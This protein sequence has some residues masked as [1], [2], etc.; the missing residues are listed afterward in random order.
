[1]G[2]ALNYH[3][4]CIP[5]DEVRAGCAAFSRRSSC[6]PCWPRLARGRLRAGGGCTSRCAL[7][8]AD[9]RPVDRARHPAA[10]RRAGGARRRRRRRSA[11]CSTGGSA[12]P[13]RAGRSR[14]A[15]T[16]S[17]RG[18]TPQRL[19]G[20]LVRGEESLRAVT[21]VEGW[22]IRQVRA[23]L[24]KAEQLQARHRRR[25][26]TPALMALL[27]RPGLHPEGRFFPDTYT[28][29]KGSQR[30]RAAAARDAR[31]G[32]AAGRGLGAARA[33]DPPLKTPD[34]ALILASIVEKETGK[35]ADRAA[36]RRRCSTTGCASACRCRPT[37]P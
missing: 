10:R 32:Q 30:R 7:P 15:A 35:A 4:R 9:G 2:H 5:L 33:A 8:A 29:S 24:A 31:H 11:T 17:K 22:N 25:W 20:K 12:C 18:I 19:L 36:D 27:G 28:Y 1:M 23:A 13:A 21:L 37:R 14:P 16:S 3:G 6:W 26:P 34:E